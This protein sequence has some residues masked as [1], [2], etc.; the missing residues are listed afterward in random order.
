MKAPFSATVCCSMMG[1]STRVSGG[2]LRY[3]MHKPGELERGNEFCEK[4]LPTKKQS[5]FVGTSPSNLQARSPFTLH[6][7]KGMLSLKR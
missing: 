3:G 4:T 6:A 5:R 7:G 1:L 2:F